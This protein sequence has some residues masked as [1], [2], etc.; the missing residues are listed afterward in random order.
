[1]YNNYYDN[2]RAIKAHSMQ[3]LAWLDERKKK[4]TK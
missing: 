1:M 4:I 3:F 2:N